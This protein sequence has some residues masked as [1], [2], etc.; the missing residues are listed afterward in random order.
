MS[1]VL[2]AGDAKLIDKKK[3]FYKLSSGDGYI[4]FSKFSKSGVEINTVNAYGASSHPDS[5]HYT[6]QMQMFV[7]KKLKQ[8]YLDMSKYDPKTLNTYHPK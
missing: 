8:M 5:P 2:R 3:G 7:D 1:E 6:D 4:I